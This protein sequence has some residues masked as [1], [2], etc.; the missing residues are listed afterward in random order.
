M[1]VSNTNSILST[2]NDIKQKKSTYT[3]SQKRANHNWRQTH[4][5]NM[6]KNSKKWSDNNKEQ[7]A[8]QS[9]DYHFLHYPMKREFRMLCSIY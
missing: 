3:E 1:S 6:R 9:R 7:E 5:E 4:Q 8:K 2:S